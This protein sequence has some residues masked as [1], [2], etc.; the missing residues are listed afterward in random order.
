[1]AD[2]ARPRSG[3]TVVVSAAAGAV[4]SIVGQLARIRG[5]R[6]VGIAGGAERCAHVVDHLGFEACVDRRAAEWRERLDAATPDGIDVD[7]ENAGGEVMDHVLT[8]LTVGARVVLSGMISTYN[9]GGPGQRELMQLVYK[10]ASMQG[11]LVF[12]HLG[13]AAEAA[14]H[15]AGL[16][17]IGA[18]RY[19]ETILDGLHRAP[20]AMTQVLD[21]TKVGKMLVHIAD[22]V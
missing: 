3:E 19:D 7:M 9:D 6:V 4:G 11:L 8:R 5:A 12:D 22:P 14:T 17:T 16:L 21:G 20:E 10:R 2:M 18:L 13:R 1:M 15:L